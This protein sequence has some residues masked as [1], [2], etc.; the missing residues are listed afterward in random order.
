MYVQ[1]QYKKEILSKAFKRK[2]TTQ[3]LK[4]HF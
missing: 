4:N 2:Q 3:T 1:N